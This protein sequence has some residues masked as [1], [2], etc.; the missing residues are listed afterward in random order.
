MPAA[1]MMEGG[2]SPGEQ[3]PAMETTAH[4]LQVILT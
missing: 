2:H 4:R 3:L 1:E